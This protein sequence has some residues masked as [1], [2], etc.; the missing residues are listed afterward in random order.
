MNPGSQL[1]SAR[2]RCPYAGGFLGNLGHGEALEATVV[3]FK[4]RPAVAKA[5][6]QRLRR[7]CTL[8]EQR[9]ICSRTA[10][11]LTVM[12]GRYPPPPPPFTSAAMAAP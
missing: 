1:S 3:R 12:R 10:E 6:S 2:S 7:D 11:A 4:G 5:L 8:Q 9:D